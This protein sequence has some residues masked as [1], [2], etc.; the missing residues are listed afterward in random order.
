MIVG[1]V[2]DEKEIPQAVD[3]EAL[4]AA[5]I[6]ATKKFYGA[7]KE[8]KVVIDPEGSDYETYR[9]WLVADPDQLADQE[10]SWNVAYHINLENARARKP[11]AQLGDELVEAVKSV[12]LRVAAHTAKQ[13]IMQR[14]R[15]A[16]REQI[17]AEYRARIGELVSGVVKKSTREFVLIDL[18]NN[19]EAILR[20]ADMLPK[21]AFRVGDRVRAYLKE[22]KDDIR[23][24]QLI[25]SRACPEM[26]IELFKI[27][28]PE[29]G[30]GSIEI[31]GAAR[32]AGIRAKVAVLAKDNR[33]DPIGA[34]VGMRGARVLAVSKE[35]GGERVDIVPWNENPAQY[36]IN[37]LA[38]AEVKSI[39]VDDDAHS[40]DIVVTNDQLAMAIGKNGQNVRLAS[41]LCGWEL[42][43]ISEDQAVEKDANESGR[44]IEMFTREL[45][46]DEDIARLLIESGFTDI[47]E[48]AYVADEDLLEIEGFDEAIIAELRQRA[49]EGLLARAIALES[50]ALAGS[51]LLAVEGMTE[52]LA[53][54]LV[55]QGIRTRDELA[56]CSTEELADIQDLTEKQAGV[57]IMAARAHRFDGEQGA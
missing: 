32:D 8:F 5:L 16:K 13:V 21:E 49:Q 26:L 3:F 2:S 45:G 1:M 11:D 51:D 29:I 39:V 18:N 54:A 37:A 28:V 35:L 17:V 38:P 30:E 23:G 10:I 46:V 40:M 7:E 44:L 52:D 42:N 57:L 36:V 22:A 41:I 27:E 6:S 31:M 56:E 33:I 34:C 50:S 25:V 53:K 14:L 47:E 9:I 24:P 48:I 19:A 12:E 15:A 55:A 43:V 4:E 20:R